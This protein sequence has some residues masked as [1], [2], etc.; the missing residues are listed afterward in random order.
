MKLGGRMLG[1]LM[2]MTCDF[3]EAERAAV[4]RAIFERRDVRSQFIPDPIPDDVLNRILLAAHHAPSVGF[5][6]PWDFILIRDREVRSLIRD[7]F[8]EANRRAAETYQGQQRT[9]YE[10]LKL[11]GILDSPLNICVTCDRA[12]TLGSGLGRHSAPETDLYSTVCAVQNLWL[13]ARAEGVGVGW[14]SI[15]DAHRLGEILGVPPRVT[16]IAYLCVGYV[17]Q[18]MEAPDLEKK[19]WCRRESLAGLLHYDGWQGRR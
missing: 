17:S 10:Q 4:Y 19:G 16:P 7:D 14:V 18:F 9:A 5:M 11:E 3:T 2:V 15:L 1:Y 6:Q 12:R 8:Q 13:A